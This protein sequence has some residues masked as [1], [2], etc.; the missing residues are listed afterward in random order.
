M[1]YTFALLVLFL[2]ITFKSVIAAA[3]EPISLEYERLGE[4]GGP[5][6]MSRSIMIHI[7]RASSHL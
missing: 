3:G 5:I 6:E 1:H 7:M 2:Y 4:C